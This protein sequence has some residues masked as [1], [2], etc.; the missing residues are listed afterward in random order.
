MLID[1]TPTDKRI[2]E[3]GAEYGGDHGS[4]KR[5]R[6][7]AWQ[8][9]R[10]SMREVE[11]NSLRKCAEIEDVVSISVINCDFT[12]IVADNVDVRAAAA[13]EHVVKNTGCDRVDAICA[14]HFF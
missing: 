6:P 13:V 2:V 12:S 5:K 8:R 10:I 11:I 1:R 7:T 3:V 9:M 4:A 14:Q